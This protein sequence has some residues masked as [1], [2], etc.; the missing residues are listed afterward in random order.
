MGKRIEKLKTY[1]QILLALAGTLAIFFIVFVGVLAVIDFYPRH[2][3]EEGMIVTEEV[4]RLNEQGLRKEIISIESL[5]VIDSV[6]QIVLFPITHSRLGEEES[7]D[8]EL[9]GLTNSF[10]GGYYDGSSGYVYNNLVIQDLIEKST[11]VIFKDRIG[12]SGFSIYNHKDRKYIVITGSEK[13]SNKDELLN[14][15]D[16][17]EL[18]IYDLGF[19]ALSKIELPKNATVLNVYDEKKLNQFIVRIGIDRDESGILKDE[20]IIYM[21]MNFEEMKVESFLN[22]ETLITLQKILEGNN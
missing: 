16:F 7:Y 2:Y 5:E 17:Q 22:E 20:P 6:N 21:R 10:S 12:I 14:D 11:G 15:Q 3:E 18:Y 8:K 13:D 19:D 9:L 4:V 1:N